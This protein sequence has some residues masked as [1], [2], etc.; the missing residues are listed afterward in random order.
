MS[1]FRRQSLEYYKHRLHG[2]VLLLPQL[3]H[4]I[5]TSCLFLWVVMVLIW[6]VLSTYSRKETVIGWLEPPEGIT[7]VYAETTGIVK[8][9]LVTEGELVAKDQPLL[10]IIDE[11][12]LASGDNLS[13]N[14]LR[15]YN[16][17]Q[18]MLK[19]QLARTHTTYEMHAKDIVKKIISA[20][21][22]LQL[23]GTQL[24]T[25]NDRYTL[26]STQVERFRALKRDGHVSSV[27]FDSAIA[28][29]LALKSDQQS[30][31][32]SQISQKNIIEQLQTELKLLPDNKANKI[33]QL[34]GSLSEISQQIVQLG[35]RDSQ[36]IK[37]PRAGT[38]N[39]IQARDGQKTTANNNIPLLTLFPDDAQLTAQLLVPVRSIGF[40]EL[41]QSLAIRY[42]A[43]PYQKF[44]IHGGAISQV[45]KTLLLPNE[46]LNVPFTLNEPVYRVTALLN[47]PNVQAYNR[48]F[49]LKPGMTIS[50]DISLGDRPLIQWLFEPIYS[51]KG[52][53]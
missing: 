5:L 7:R 43:F 32:R 38:V 51:L 30:F 4:S 44:G 52:R 50:A 21:Q 45:S 37:A 11:R 46:L 25:L 13:V 8:K 6:L 10:V 24:S 42:D 29:E 41:G 20:Q 22:D 12:I 26:I 27:A 33:D 19:E 53:I 15:E 39:N 18:K 31:L 34:K 47:K 23:I 9:V 48:D 17:Q 14:L 2:D 1:L 3:S 16:N 35:S 49:A 36:I 28:Q 40:V